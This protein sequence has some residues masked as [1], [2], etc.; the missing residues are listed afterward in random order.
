MDN[1]SSKYFETQLKASTKQLKWHDTLV[2]LDVE[3]IHKP[4]WDNVLPN[5]LNR[6]EDL[7]WR[8]M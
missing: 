8:N 2:L 5:A 1:V 4:I 3:L 7:K 6:Q